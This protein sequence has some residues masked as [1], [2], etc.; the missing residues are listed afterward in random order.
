MDR[1]VFICCMFV[2]LLSFACAAF[3][4]GG[5]TP[6][7]TSTPTSASTVIF[8]PANTATSTSTPAQI[9][10]PN[11][12]KTPA[13][14]VGS[15]QI[16]DKDGMLMVYVPQGE[17]TMGSNVGDADQKPA[18]TV[19]L[20]AYWI[21]RTE[22]TNAMYA[23]CVA[24]GQCQEHSKSNSSTYSSY[25]GNS[26]YADFPVIYVDW[27]DASAYCAWAGG[28]LPSEAEWEKA[29]RGTDGRLY[30]WG[31]AAPTCSL[32]NFYGGTFCVGDTSRVG[33]YPSAASPY[34]ALDMA[35]N[36]W[37]WLN[38]WYGDN[39]YS[40]SPSSNPPGPSSGSYRVLRGGSWGSNDDYVRSALRYRFNPDDSDYSIGFR[41]SR[42]H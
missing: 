12:T 40:T 36:V 23:K 8:T 14:G 9:S 33:S 37:E 25:Y 31:N 38:D 27:N 3:P 39:Y 20:D 22:V 13:L 2:L 21:D 16:S 11:P 35:G 15:T 4:S 19:Y 30:P 7:P 26:T 42:S 5:S 32:A 28:R 24:A 6:T 41:C 1:K 10:T 34:G 18:H 17:F 29:A